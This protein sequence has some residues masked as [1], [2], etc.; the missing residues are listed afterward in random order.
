M[1]EAAEI[2]VMLAAAPAALKAMILLGINCGF[3]NTDVANLTVKNLD[4]KGGWCNYPR[5]KTGISRRCPLWPETVKAIKAALEPRRNRT[6]CRH[7]RETS[8]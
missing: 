1:F 2:R 6:D 5:P 8:T 4:L 7:R 3:G